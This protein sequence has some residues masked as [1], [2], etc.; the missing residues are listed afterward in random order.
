MKGIEFYSTAAQIIPILLLV[1]V[2]EVR[3]FPLAFSLSSL[4]RAL[5]FALLAII[6]AGEF[7]AL[8]V[9]QVD[10]TNQLQL[11]LVWSALG[12]ETGLLF[13]TLSA[14]WGQDKNKSGA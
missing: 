9:L 13:G 4:Y 1:L 2:I 8:H 5:A 10:D 3:A 6:V 7:S 14:G 11:T 12:L